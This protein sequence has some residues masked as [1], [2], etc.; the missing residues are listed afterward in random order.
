M[1]VFKI[2]FIA[3]LII[4]DAAAFFYM[5]KGI[6]KE[7]EDPESSLWIFGALAVIGIELVLIF[8][9]ITVVYAYFF[10]SSPWG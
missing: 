7:E 9:L 4:M 1:I 2:F 8:W 6:R 5:P 10:G 3:L